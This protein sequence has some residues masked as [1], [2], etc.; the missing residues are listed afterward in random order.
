MVW[1]ILSLTSVFLTDAIR[2]MSCDGAKFLCPF[3]VE[4]V[5]IK[6]DVG[7]DFHQDWTLGGSSK[8]ESFVYLQAPPAE[9]L[10]H[11]G[12]GAGCASGCNQVGPDGTKQPFIFGIK[13]L[14][15]SAQIFQKAF[16]RTLQMEHM[17]LDE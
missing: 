17:S 8:E 3:N 11:T 6:E 5:V 4:H 2:Y 15:Q 16:Q 1:F 7:P 10:Q 14:L 12:A 13:L 9:G